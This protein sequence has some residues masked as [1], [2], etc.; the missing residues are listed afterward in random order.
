[1]L[2]EAFVNVA[3][4]ERGERI[5]AGRNILENEVAVGGGEGLCVVGVV[6]VGDGKFGVGDG[7]VGSGVDDDAGDVGG[8]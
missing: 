7:S 4:R 8:C 6:G 3:G 2:I 1:M 5:F